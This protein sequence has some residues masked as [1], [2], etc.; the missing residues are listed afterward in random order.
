MVMYVEPI[1]RERGIMKPEDGNPDIGYIEIL[2]TFTN[3][4][5]EEVLIQDP[6]DKAAQ[7]ELRRRRI[8]W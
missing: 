3:R 8:G 6:N 5:S 1:G 2:K 4:M 7:I